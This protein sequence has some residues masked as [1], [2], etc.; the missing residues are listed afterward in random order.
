VQIQMQAF[1][2]IRR[3]QCL[4]SYFLATLAPTS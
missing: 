3:L 2:F 1:S 4:F